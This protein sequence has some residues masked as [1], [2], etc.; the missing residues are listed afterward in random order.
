M[1]R[2]S[3]STVTCRPDNSSKNDRKTQINIE[4][5]DIFP[6]QKEVGDIRYSAPLTVKRWEKHVPPVPH[7]IVDVIIE[8]V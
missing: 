4:I 7:Q 6:F 1:L 3:E 5:R 8:D 2:I